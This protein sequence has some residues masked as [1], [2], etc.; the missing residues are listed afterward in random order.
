MI[1]TIIIKSLS[2]QIIVRKFLYIFFNNCVCVSYSP[3]FGQ[4][5]CVKLPWVFTHSGG[6][7]AL[8][9]NQRLI[10]FMRY[11]KE[12]F[13]LRRR[14]KRQKVVLFP[15]FSLNAGSDAASLRRLPLFLLLLLCVHPSPPPPF[16]PQSAPPSLLLLLLSSP[17]ARQLL[18]GTAPSS[19][20]SLLFHSLHSLSAA[21]WTNG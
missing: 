8:L 2:L 9:D 15:S 17:P 12:R 6:S 21:V 18:I 16:T 20:L 3:K 13:N 11:F 14:S 19:L 4:T 10:M 1:K 7:S 5:L